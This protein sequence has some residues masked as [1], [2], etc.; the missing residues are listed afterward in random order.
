MHRD[1]ALPDTVERV[2]HGIDMHSACTLYMHMHTYVKND[3]KIARALTPRG[4]G[5]HV[6]TKERTRLEACLN[7][8]LA[9]PQ[10]TPAH[11]ARNVVY[12]GSIATDCLASVDRIRR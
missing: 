9:T 5:L 7:L 6:A 3:K 8:L 4:E 12:T 11:H 2:N 10:V 1:L